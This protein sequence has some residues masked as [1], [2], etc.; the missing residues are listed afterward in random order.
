MPKII[1]DL[2]KEFYP[3]PKP[4]KQVKLPKVSLKPGKRTIAWNEERSV[5]KTE[6]EKMGIVTCE[7]RYTNCWKNTALGFA[8]PEKRRNMTFE[9]LPCVILA[10]NSCHDTLELYNRVRMRKVIETVIKERN[11]CQK[12]F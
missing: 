5:L 10:C 4:N 3:M 2:S 9:D 7:L 8:H 11:K 6:F 1:D 12:P